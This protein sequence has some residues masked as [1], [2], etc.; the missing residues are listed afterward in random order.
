MP[1]GIKF[2]NKGNIY[3]DTHFQYAAPTG[4]QAH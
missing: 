2:S 1:I 4:I 3:S